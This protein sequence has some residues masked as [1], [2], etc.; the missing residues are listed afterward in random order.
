ML[1]IYIYVCV[2]GSVCVAH[3]SC[4]LS[5]L[6]KRRRSWKWRND[7]N[8]YIYIYIYISRASCL[9]RSSCLLKK[10]VI[11][12]TVSRGGVRCFW[13]GREELKKYNVTGFYFF[14]SDFFNYFLFRM[15]VLCS[16]FNSLE[17]KMR[18]RV[19]SLSNWPPHKYFLIN[20]CCLMQKNKKKLE[21]HD[22][23][24]DKSE[25]WCT[26]IHHAF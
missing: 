3:V 2:C 7:S 22:I 18:T 1:I 24:C 16:R 25:S 15:C 10:L 17:E 26:S 19:P 21:V 13:A 23:C 9:L 4:Q 8:I 20:G 12:S 11:A 5:G 14:K 6:I